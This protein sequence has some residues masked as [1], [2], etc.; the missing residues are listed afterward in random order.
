[1]AA[2]IRITRE[3]VLEAALELVRAGGPEALNARALAKALGCSTQ[4]IFR[5]FASMEALR[6]AVLE[7]AH[8]L[9][10]RRLRAMEAASPDHPYKARG[11]AY[12]AFAGEEPMLF[13]M[14]FMRHRREGQPSPE[15]LDWP[16]DIALAGAGT[17]LTGQAAERFHLE[18]WALVHGVAVMRA[19]GYLELDEATVSRTLTDVYLGVK[20]IWEATE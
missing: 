3:R 13:R 7:R 6:T 12:I 4:P 11:M 14:L 16:E 18:M 1:M 8:S 20:K 19:T 10:R 5:C 15:D 17:G 2:P 9:Y